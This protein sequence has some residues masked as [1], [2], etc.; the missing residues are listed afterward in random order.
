M[1]SSSSPINPVAVVIPSYR[2]RK[3]IMAVISKIGPEVDRIYVVDD[4]CPEN[5][6]AYVSEFC[7][8]G[9]VQVVKNEKNL[10][11]GGA[12]M[13]GYVAALKD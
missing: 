9:R 1:N 11:V 2:V 13:V 12:V 10:G 4:C 7:T 5:T 8:D 6:G 3:H